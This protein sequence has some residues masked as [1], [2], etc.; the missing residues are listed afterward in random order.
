M[1]GNGC[2]GRGGRR[3]V[4]GGGG[5]EEDGEKGRVREREEWGGRGQK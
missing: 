2:K 3:V 1:E 5:G 4:G